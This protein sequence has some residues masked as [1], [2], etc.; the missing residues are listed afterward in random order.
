MLVLLTQLEVSSVCR[1]L[2]SG[3]Q[4]PH[5]RLYADEQ[6]PVSHVGQPPIKTC[7][8]LPR[9]T[10]ATGNIRPSSGREHLS[11]NRKEGLVRGLSS[12]AIPNLVL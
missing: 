5:G 7:S 2:T 4:A 3:N 8:Q 10:Q 6:N 1:Q 9:L 11:V 12:Q